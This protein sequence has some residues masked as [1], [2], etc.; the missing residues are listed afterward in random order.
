MPFVEVWAQKI[1][2]EGTER[3]RFADCSTLLM[4]HGA[5]GDSGRWKMQQEFRCFSNLIAVDLPGHGRSGGEGLNTV[6]EYATFIEQ[7]VIDMQLENLV[8][9]GHSMGG[10]IALEL[11]LNRPGLLIGLILASTG[12]KLRVAP[13]ALES[14]KRGE[15]NPAFAKKAFSKN[16]PQELIDRFALE[17]SQ[18]EHSVRYGDFLACD[19]FDVISQ[20]SEIKLPTLIICGDE[21]KMTPLKYSKFL[22]EKITN[23]SLMIISDAGHLVMQEKPQQFNQAVVQFMKSL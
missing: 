5:G 4:I 3:E 21:D 18:G 9:L 10:A 12:A 17:S 22:H 1:Y 16:A 13:E 11:T 6:R 2:Y 20:V 14:Y 23:S 15:Y 19:G 8:I 7:L